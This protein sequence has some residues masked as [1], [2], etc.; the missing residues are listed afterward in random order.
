MGLYHREK[1]ELE[2]AQ[3]V[4]QQALFL[5]HETGR[6]MLLWR[7]HAGLASVAPNKALANVHD[8]IASEIILQILDPIEDE[9]LCQTFKN[10]PPVRAIFDRV[11]K[12]A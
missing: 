1:G 9:A 2:E 8:R 6:R 4:W 5:A 7:I 11:K 12:A 10:A 3:Q